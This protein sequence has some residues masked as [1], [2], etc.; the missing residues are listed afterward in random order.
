MEI[1]F[2]TLDAL[3]PFAKL[4]A[5]RGLYDGRTNAQAMVLMRLC[6]HKFQFSPERGAIIICTR[7]VGH[8]ESGWWKNPDYER[9]WHVSISYR[10][11]HDGPREVDVLL[12][13]D[14]RQSEV[15]VR[16]FFGDDAMLTWCE[17]PFSDRG[18]VGDVWHYRLFCDRGWQPIKPRGE[19]YS[20]RDT[21][22]DWKSFSE[23]HGY[24]PEAEDAPFFARSSE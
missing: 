16:A 4:R 24:K 6:T 23:I 17:P 13:Q 12:N 19:V 9:C 11:H 20:K 15:I 5:M 14:R 21:P 2:S 3:V 1:A 7:D 10:Q 22:A 18:K 8:H